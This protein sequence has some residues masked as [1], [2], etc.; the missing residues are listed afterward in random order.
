MAALPVEQVGVEAR[1]TSFSNSSAVYQSF[2]ETCPGGPQPFGIPVSSGDAVSVAVY[3]NQSTGN[4]QF[5][6]VN[7]TKA[8]GSEMTEPCKHNSTCDKTT[9]VIVEV[10]T[11]G[12]PEYDLPDFGSVSFSGTTVTSFDGTKGDL[13]SGSL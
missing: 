12:P 1:C 2:W 8:T 5:T 11:P 4:F 13:C 7:N 6:F 10:Q 9:E 3:Y